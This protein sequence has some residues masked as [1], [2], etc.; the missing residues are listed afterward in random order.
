MFVLGQKATSGHIHAMSGL[1]PIADIDALPSAKSGHS[2][3]FLRSLRPA[4]EDGRRNCNSFAHPG[5]RANDPEAAAN[6][7]QTRHA[8][9]AALIHNRLLLRVA[10]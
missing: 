2:P 5:R 3:G 1:T 8:I 10:L 9:E 4:N 7:E 6:S